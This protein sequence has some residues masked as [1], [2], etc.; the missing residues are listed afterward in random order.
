[1]IKI[2]ET[3]YNILS[4]DIEVT[5][6]VGN[7]IFPLVADTNTT[8]PFIIYRKNS[9]VPEYTKDGISKKS[10]TVEIVIASDKYNIGVDLADKVFKAISAKDR[11]FRLQNNTEDFI[12]DTFI[13][14]LIY[15]IEK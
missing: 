13:Q 8:F 12:E 3:V 4:T 1:M 15:N 9:Y 14:T 10:A 7:K 5:N 11:K 2:G 6:V